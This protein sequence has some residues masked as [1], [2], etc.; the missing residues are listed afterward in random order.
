MNNKLNNFR[1]GF[2]P[3]ILLPFVSFILIWTFVAKGQSMADFIHSSMQRHVLTKFLSLAVVPNLLLFYF[4][5]WKE[6]ARAYKGVVAATFVA[7]I[8]ILVS[9]IF[10]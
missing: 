4:F 3:G 2:I 7:A 6:Y 1:I 10:I 5:I 9:Q 8:I